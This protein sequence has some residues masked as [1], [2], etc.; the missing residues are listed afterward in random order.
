MRMHTCVSFWLLLAWVLPV[1]AQRSSDKEGTLEQG[2]VAT[3]T[4]PAD[5]KQQVLDLAKEWV[6]AEINTT[7]I[8]F[9]VFWMTSSLP[10]LEPSNHTTKKVSSS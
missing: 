7:R 10:A 9:G 1:H 5:A 6:A 8:L 3:A 4:G 2:I